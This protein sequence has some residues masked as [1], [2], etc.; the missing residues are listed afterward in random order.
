[1]LVKHFCAAMVAISKIVK[2]APIYKIIS[3]DVLS[4]LKEYVVIR[5]RTEWMTEIITHITRNTCPNRMF[6]LETE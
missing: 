5:I 3:Q 2:G 1:M 4:S 6:I